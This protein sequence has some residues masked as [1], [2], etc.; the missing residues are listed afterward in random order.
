VEAAGD[1]ALQ[2]VIFARVDRLGRLISGSEKAV[3][4]GCLVVGHGFSANIE[5]PQAAGCRLSFD[6]AGR[7]WI[8]EVD[9]SMRTSLPGIYAAGEITAVAGA[10]KSFIEGRIAG[11][12]IAG[13][14]GLAGGGGDRRRMSALRRSRASQI[15]FGRLMH[16][17]CTPPV[18]MWEHI[19]DGTII[20]RCE[21]VTIGDIRRSI[22]NG[23]RTA[24][25]IKRA[26]R[27]GMGM[28]QG[29]TCGPILQDL[30]SAQT[31]RHEPIIPFS[32]RIPVKPV[33]VSSILDPDESHLG[34][35]DAP[36]IPS[37]RE[38]PQD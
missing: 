13:D 2:K 26:T 7:G 25:G 24:G 3:R 1:G 9:E 19:P 27:C 31:G 15:R 14:L 6:A 29:R 8:V 20:C 32:A 38:R 34:N 36:V 33:D 21:D 37:S 10:R 30:L 17:I 22:A 35:A 16:R 28:C 11:L 18:G 23:A 12:S 5:L 4:T